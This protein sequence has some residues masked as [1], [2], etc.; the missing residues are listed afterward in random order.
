MFLV[1]F[2]EFLYKH[3]HLLSCGRTSNIEPK[4]NEQRVAAFLSNSFTAFD[5]YSVSGFHSVK[6]VIPLAQVYLPMGILL[7]FVL[8]FCFGIRQMAYSYRQNNEMA[9]AT[10]KIWKGILRTTPNYNIFELATTY[11][12][13]PR[14]HEK[15]PQ[16]FVTFA[17]TKKTISIQYK[18]MRAKIHVL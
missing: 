13:H 18:R 8:F 14:R 1:T 17:S 16:T 2:D 15:N 7:P 10:M 11:R 9:K 3:S 4:S 6:L 5:M 12:H